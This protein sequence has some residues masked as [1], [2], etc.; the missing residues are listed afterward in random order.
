MYAC[1]L[2]H[3]DFGFIVLGSAHDKTVSEMTQLSG[4][5]IVKDQGALCRLLPLDAWE[6]GVLIKF[7]NLF[8]NNAF[9]AFQEFHQVWFFI[10]EKRLF[11]C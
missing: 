11:E 6:V 7:A 4:R 1:V 2:K 10:G 9:Y 3:I 5:M 8:V